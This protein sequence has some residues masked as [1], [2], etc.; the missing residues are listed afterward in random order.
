MDIATRHAKYAKN[1]AMMLA[2]AWYAARQGHGM[3]NLVVIPY[4]DN[5]SSFARY[6]GN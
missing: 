4:N 3:R 6:L 5:L 1:P 2:L